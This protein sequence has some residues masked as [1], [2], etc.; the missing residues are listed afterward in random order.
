MALGCARVGVTRRASHPV[1]AARAHW[2]V[3]DCQQQGGA[4]LAACPP[5]ADGVGADLRL[6]AGWGVVAV[7]GM[8]PRHTT[9]DSRTS[10]AQLEGTACCSLPRRSAH[11]ALLA[12]AARPPCPSPVCRAWA[13]ARAHGN[14]D[15]GLGAC[16]AGWSSHP[17]TPL[18][19]AARSAQ[20]PKLRRALHPA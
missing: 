3:L 10:P 13:P 9:L 1:S 14:H 19:G 4:L 7:Q 8:H 11:P 12:G 5:R 15:G 2:A 17:Q 16:R 6:A 20:G 18:P